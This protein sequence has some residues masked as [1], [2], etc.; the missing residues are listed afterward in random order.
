MPDPVPVPQTPAPTSNT[1]L[2]PGGARASGGQQQGYSDAGHPAAILGATHEFT[3]P[4]L[5]MRPGSG[6]AGSV[7]SG[8]DDPP[9]SPD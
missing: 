3:A 2:L 8:A 1:L 4:G 5:T 9:F 7:V 6:F